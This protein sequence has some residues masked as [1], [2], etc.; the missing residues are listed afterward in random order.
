MII[1]LL[2][3]TV[4][5]EKMDAGRWTVCV[6]G[7]A[8][9]LIVI[10]P[11]FADASWAL[12]LPLVSA[13]AFAIFSI[14]TRF[15]SAHDS[16]RATFFHSGLV[17]FIVISIAAPFAWRWPSGPE[18]VG[19]LASG[20]LAAAS[21]YFFIKA[22]QYQTASVIAPFSYTEI[23]WGTIL[24]YLVFRDFPDAWTWL[25]A[26]VIVASGLYII[27]R[28]AGRVRGEGAEGAT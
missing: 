22:N 1:S 24:G 7:L 10:R 17:S 26:A 6:I 3:A 15:L 14:I 23:I 9:A 18:W 13:V 25:G 27:R 2:A 5:K 8:G 20:L 21:Q 28:E 19:L 4:L 16:A 11:G 12:A